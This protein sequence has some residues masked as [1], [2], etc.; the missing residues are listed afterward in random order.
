MPSQDDVYRK[1]LSALIAKYSH[2]WEAWSST[3]IE[4]E[5]RLRALQRTQQRLN[6]PYEIAFRRDSRDFCGMFEES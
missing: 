1:T 4:S 3:L 6:R 2:R 5:E